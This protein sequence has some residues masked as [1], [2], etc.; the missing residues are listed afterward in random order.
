MDFIIIG[1]LIDY[2]IFSHNQKFLKLIKKNT[3]F[4]QLKIRIR[5]IILKQSLM[6]PNQK[7]KEVILTLFRQGKYL[8]YDCILNYFILIIFFIFFHSYI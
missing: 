8:Y 7:K 3:Q 5:R 6:T 4:K 1:I 2:F